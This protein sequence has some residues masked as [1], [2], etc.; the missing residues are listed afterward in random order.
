M[1]VSRK[2]KRMKP[3]KSVMVLGHR[4]KIEYT[5]WD[6]GQWGSC[7]LDGRSIKLS[8]ACLKEP[9]QHWATLVHEVTHMIFGMSGLAFMECNSEEAYVR[10]I[11]ALVVPWITDN[12]YLRDR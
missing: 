11:E 8:K 7:D 6:D 1:G 9:H 10:C 12:A 5:V 4:I 3:L 2:S